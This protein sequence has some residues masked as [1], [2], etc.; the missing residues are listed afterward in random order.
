MFYVLFL[1]PQQKK[2]VLVS[3][4]RLP[5]RWKVEAGS[6]L[7][8]VGASG[9]GKSTVLRLL[10]RLYDPQS[11]TIE[12]DGVPLNTLEPR[13]LRGRV[14][15]SSLLPLRTSSHTNSKCCVHNSVR[16]V[17][18]GLKGLF[19]V[20]YMRL[21]SWPYWLHIFPVHRTNKRKKEEGRSSW[22]G[23]R[24]IQRRYTDADQAASLGLN[25]GS[26]FFRL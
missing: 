26:F 15:N 18:E 4:P 24:E 22:K 21:F 7:A 3:L 25:L 1:S 2:C 17:R 23:G 16:A 5:G 12:L 6:S 13:G 20:V 8:I 9:C 11:G 10:T 19:V 14:R